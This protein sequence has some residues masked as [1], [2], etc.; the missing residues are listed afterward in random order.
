MTSRRTCRGD[1]PSRMRSRT[2]TP[3]DLRVRSGRTNPERSATLSR[4][5]VWGTAP[6]SA[7]PWAPVSTPATI[8]GPGPP[9]RPAG[10]W[11]CPRPPPPAGRRS[12]PRPDDGGEDHVGPRPAP[13]GVGRG[14]GQID[15]SSVQPR[16]L[17]DAVP[18]GRGEAGGQADLD[19]GRRAGRPW[20]R[21]L[22]AGGRSRPGRRPRRRR[23]RRRRWPPRLGRVPGEQLGE[24]LDLRLAH[25]PLHEFVRGRPPGS[26]VAD[27]AHG[28]PGPGGRPARPRRRRTPSSRPCPGRPDR[29]A[30]VIGSSSAQV[31]SA[32]AGDRVMPR[33][34]RPVTTTTPGADL[35]P[36]TD[37]VVGGRRVHAGPPAHHRRQR[38][39]Q[40]GF[41]PLPQSVVEELLHGEVEG[42]VVDVGVADG[43][44]A[45]GPL[46]EQK[47]HPEGHRLRRRGRQAGPAGPV[48]GRVVAHR[49]AVGH[50]CGHRRRRRCRLHHLQPAPPQRGA[51]PGRPRSTRP[52][53][54]GRHR[55]RRGPVDPWWRRRRWSVTVPV[56]HLAPPAARGATGSGP[57]LEVGPAARRGRPAVRPRRRAG[58]GRPP[59]TF[60]RMAGLAARTPSASSTVS[61][62]AAASGR[63]ATS[64][65][66]ANSAA[67]VATVIEPLARKP[68]PRG[69]SGGGSPTA[70]GPAGP[71]PVPPRRPARSPTPGRSSAP[72]PAGGRR[73]PRAGPP[74]SPA[75]RPRGRASSRSRRRR[76]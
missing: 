50:R 30:G 6:N 68:D 58:T 74:P 39:A 45:A 76:R 57:P 32:T 47:L 70:R 71:A 5:C 40:D 33:P 46:D 24:D 18:G 66:R 20:S 15:R 63:A 13:P 55:D 10:H 65:I 11:P 67:S 1:R 61:S 54:C 22:P 38:P 48:E 59:S 23:P 12:I 51:R 27:A 42:L 41:G 9:A 7:R 34:A 36:D 69:Q 53:P 43:E 4:I 31:S 25:G 56:S 60:P 16:A 73:R 29:M 3:G 75:G 19:A 49:V 8:A 62:R 72:R 37:P 17:E 26:V 28:L 64:S 21:P 2:F 35:V 44:A 14:Q 52:G